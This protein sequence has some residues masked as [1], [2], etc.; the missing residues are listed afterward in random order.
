[1]SCFYLVTSALI[2]RECSS[3]MEK[4]GAN[5]PN[6]CS[7]SNEAIRHARIEIL[8][9]N[10]SHSDA[11]DYLQAFY[12]NDIASQQSTSTTEARK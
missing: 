10:L 8:K 6:F 3:I 4:T 2:L 9:D 1:M 11:F 7:L 12:D 5:V